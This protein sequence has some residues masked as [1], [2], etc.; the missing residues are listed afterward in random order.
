MAAE[1][2]YTLLYCKIILKK[3]TEFLRLLATTEQVQRALEIFVGGILSYLF[4]IFLNE[5]CNAKT[6]L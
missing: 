1:I 2:S 6:A 5:N 3:E 4:R